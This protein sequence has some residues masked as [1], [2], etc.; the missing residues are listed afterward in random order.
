MYVLRDQSVAEEEHSPGCALAAGVFITLALVGIV[1]CLSRRRRQKVLDTLEAIHQSPEL[2][3]RVEAVSGI[4][5]PQ[6][7]G[8]KKDNQPCRARKCFNVLLRIMV[9]LALSFL[10][11][12]LAARAPLAIIN[13]MIYTDEET[14][15]TVEPK[16]VSVL[17]V[18]ISFLV[19][20]I[21]AIKKLI[22]SCAARRRARAFAS[23]GTSPSLPLSSSLPN[24]LL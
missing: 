13:G 16:P 14:G 21:V 8:A 6:P 10:L 1:L 2:K 18:F 11:V 5:V 7:C 24:P 15:E 22:V 17:V 9:T 19:V 12:N 23:S 20:E 3:A 4:P